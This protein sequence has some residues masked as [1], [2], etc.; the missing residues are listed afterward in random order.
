MRV[1]RASRIAGTQILMFHRVR[2][3]E[4]TAFGL[5]DCYRLRGTSLTPTEFEQALAEAGPV[6]SLG[7]VEEALAQGLDPPPG[8]VLTFDDGYR[9]HLDLVAPRLAARGLTGTFYVATGL[10]GAGSDVAL[11]DAW[12]WLLDHATRPS[13]SIELPHGA[14]YR[15]RV[16]TLRGKS[17]WVAGEPKTALLTASP[18]SQGQ[19]VAALAEEVGCVL[20]D[21]LAARLYLRPD[22]WPALCGAGMR[23]GAHSIRHPRL[24]EVDEGALRLEV[25]G[26]IA[27]VRPF[28]EPVAFA[29]PDGAHDER[30]ANRVRGAGASSGVTCE[31]GLVERGADLMKL[32]RMFV[33]SPAA[34]L[35]R[36]VMRER[37]P[38]CAGA[39]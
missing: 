21:D 18:E 8:T 13:A 14:E 30:V 10:H 27:A 3:A 20:P 32:P 36:D 34:R 26:S 17:A 37:A 24:T 35:L 2:P 1:E 19:M 11:V 28:C 38:G 16:D 15:G 39:R 22:E 23:L 31:P 4:P 12:Y 7:A 9:E 5:P 25:M 6:L 29:Y 33:A